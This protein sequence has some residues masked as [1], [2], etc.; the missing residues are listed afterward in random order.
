VRR[1]FTDWTPLPDKSSKQDSES[2]TEVRVVADNHEQPDANSRTYTRF[3]NGG[4]HYT[5]GLPHINEKVADSVDTT[6]G[7]RIAVDDH[8]ALPDNRYSNEP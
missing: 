2:M 5:P 1:D 4:A 8:P 3:V 6:T 7:P